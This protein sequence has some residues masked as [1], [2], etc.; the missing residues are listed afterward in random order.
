[1]ETFAQS[2]KFNFPVHAEKEQ[3]ET[4][5]TE[6]EDDG[7]VADEGVVEDDDDDEA[8]VEEDSEGDATD[9]STVCIHIIFWNACNI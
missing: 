7:N 5:D 1:M 4:I 3:D 8:E 6:E 9:A 2:F